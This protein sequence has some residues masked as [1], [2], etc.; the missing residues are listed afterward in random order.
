MKHFKTC[1]VLFLAAL[2]LLSLCVEKQIACNSE[3]NKEDCEK[4]GGKYFVMT[5]MKS[6]PG[7]GS[8]S[9]GH[10]DCGTANLTTVCG[11][12]KCE[13]SETNNTCPQDCQTQCRLEN[14]CCCKGSGGGDCLCVSGYANGV[15]VC[16]TGQREYLSSCDDQCKPLTKCRDCSGEGEKVYGSSDF[17]PTKCCDPDAGI[18]GPWIK[19]SS[20][21]CL[22]NSDGSRGGCQNAVK[23]GDGV[24]S[25][26]ENNC[27]CPKDCQQIAGGNCSYKEFPGKCTI[28]NP[29]VGNGGGL[30]YIFV[31][32][33]KVDVSGTFLTS[34]SQLNPYSGFTTSI[35]EAIIVTGKP[36]DCTLRAEERGSCTPV[37]V[38]FTGPV[39]GKTY[40]A[41]LSDDQ[42]TECANAGGS[43]QPVAIPCP[44]TGCSQSF[45]AC[46]CAKCGNG[47]CESGETATDCP[48]DCSGSIGSVCG[49]GKCED[50]ETAV[51][52][53]RDCGNAPGNCQK[54]GVRGT[55]IQCCPGLFA[56]FANVAPVG[57]GECLWGPG[58]DRIC[59]KCGD[60]VCRIGENS[61]SCPKDCGGALADCVQEGEMIRGMGEKDDKECCPGLIEVLDQWDLDD[62]GNCLALDNYSYYCLKC[63]D[64]SCRMGE[65]KC[66]CPRDCPE[67][68]LSAGQKGPRGPLA[69][70]QSA[71]GCCAGLNKLKTDYDSQCNQAIDGGYVCTRCGDW[72]CG[73]GENECNCPQD[74]GNSIGCSPAL[75]DDLCAKAGGKVLLT[76][77]ELHCLCPS[78]FGCDNLCG[79]HGLANVNRKD[80]KVTEGFYPMD[81]GAT[82]CCCQKC[83]NLCKTAGLKYV[84][85]DPNY[86]KAADGVYPVSS[87]AMACCC[88]NP[89]TDIFCGDGF[90]TK[91][92]TKDNCPQDCSRATPICGNGFCESGEGYTN[93]PK[94]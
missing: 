6:P 59:A 80:C 83:D 11:N 70:G 47:I 63:G 68:C 53:P 61:C 42:K 94:D 2:T 24:C 12:G 44:S 89:G 67:P 87:G 30:N 65:N 10:C 86:C 85:I 40:V 88:Q 5:V 79:T 64:G 84:N 41:P 43:M 66:N 78:A 28:T 93:C 54:E 55:D 58:N 18:I 52:C 19:D 27:N 21:L 77:G 22:A 69:P 72:N 92:E 73:E 26:V 17:G 90:C 33:D 36:Y 37:I 38:V 3:M 25:S 13:S 39:C 75:K 48:N 82:T 20:G 14:T 7:S 71:P 74:C 57:N 60:G 46:N 76:S 32:N 34:P 15:R 50:R 91:G 62:L 8:I 35:P 81:N 49:N 4:S 56:I 45:Y 29:I 51:S 16:P 23:C 9:S 31:P 1:A